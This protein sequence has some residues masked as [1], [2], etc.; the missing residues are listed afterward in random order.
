VLNFHPHTSY[1]GYGLPLQEGSWQ[2]VLSTDEWRFGGAGLMPLG[3]RQ[4]AVNGWL[5]LYLPARVG[6]VW[7]KVRTVERD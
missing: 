6:M 1:T 5:Q 4:T 7:R 2:L 3:E